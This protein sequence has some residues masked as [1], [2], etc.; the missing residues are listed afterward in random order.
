MHKLAAHLKEN[1][2][3]RASKQEVQVNSEE[4]YMHP[5]K[6]DLMI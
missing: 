1:Q 2:A 5:L 4:D 3:F 6:V